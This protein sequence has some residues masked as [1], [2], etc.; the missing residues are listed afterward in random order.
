MKQH[1]A[2]ELR[3]T[4]ALVDPDST[5][6]LVSGVGAGITDLS[7][8]R[9]AQAQLENSETTHMVLL[10]YTDAQPLPQQGYISVVDPGNG[11]V[12]LYIVDYLSD[13]RM[14]RPR[15]WVEAYCHVMRTNS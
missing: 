10:R 4:A 8:H 9:L 1:T 7:G 15:V 3:Y 12:T 6:V 14:P 2:S 5:T 13:P 11:A